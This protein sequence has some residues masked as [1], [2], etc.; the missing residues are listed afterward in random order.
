MKKETESEISHTITF[1]D[2]LLRP[3]NVALLITRS[4]H[5]F[6]ARSIVL[7]LIFSAL[8]GGIYGGIFSTDKTFIFHDAYKTAI[9]NGLTVLFAYPLLAVF[10]RLFGGREV[11]LIK[12]PFKKCLSVLSISWSYLPIMLLLT[13]PAYVLSALNNLGSGDMIFKTLT[14]FSGVVSIIMLARYLHQV[15]DISYFATVPIAILIGFYMLLLAI[16]LLALLAPFKSVAIYYGFYGRAA[17]AL[18]I[19]K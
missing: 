7:L 2:L 10:L 19:V 3:R 17:E 11:L 8:V 15:Y 9:V 18:T 14:V 13:A 12:S 16:N 5:A 1:S 6:I 4:E